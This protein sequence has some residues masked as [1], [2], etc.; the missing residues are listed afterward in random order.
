MKRFLSHFIF[1][2]TVLVINSSWIFFSKNL[3]EFDDTEPEK[4]KGMIDR[5]NFWR[6]QYGL[7]NLTW[8][9]ELANVAQNWANEL[10]K[11]GCKMEHRPNNKFGENIY[12][13]SGL[14]STPKMVTDAWAD[15]KQ[16]FDFD[17]MECKLE[18]WKCGHFTQLMW[19]TT[20]KVGCGMAKCGDQEIWVCNYNPSGNWVGQKPFENKK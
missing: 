1:F 17:K 6:S 19:S 7:Q 18:W 15:E 12:W 10:A 11:R 9:S 16:Y 3:S 4:M 14:Q 2:L 8:S 20:K 13:S 5:H